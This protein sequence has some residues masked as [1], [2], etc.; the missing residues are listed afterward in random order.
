MVRVL[1][2][3]AAVIALLMFSPEAQAGG[4]PCRG[5]SCQ[6]QPAA[7]LPACVSPLPVQTLTVRDEAEVRQPLRNAVEAVRK[8]KPVRRVCGLILERRPV[9]HLVAGTVGRLLGRR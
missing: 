1:L 2:A 4:C 5:K 3:A 7:P 8:A 9:R 6:V